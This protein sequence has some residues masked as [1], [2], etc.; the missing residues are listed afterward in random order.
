[1][2]ASGECALLCHYAI[3]ILARN[4]SE[5]L[6]ADPASALL[7]SLSAREFP[8]FLAD[9]SGWDGVADHA[10]SAARRPGACHPAMETVRGRDA[11]VAVLSSLTRRAG[12]EVR[13]TTL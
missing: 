7:S 1:M 4:I 2:L 6:G 9:A 11:N 8:F 12:I 5:G 3:E 13:A 10:P